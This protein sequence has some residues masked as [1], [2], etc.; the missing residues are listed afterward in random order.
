VDAKKFA[1]D[2]HA[3]LER[4]EPLSVPIV[5]YRTNAYPGFYDAGKR[6]GGS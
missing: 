5:G 1:N 2:I 4:F 3:T 6:D